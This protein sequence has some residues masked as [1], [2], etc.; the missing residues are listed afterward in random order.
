MCGASGSSSA[1]VRC[2]VVAW[3]A[4]PG[5]NDVGVVVLVYEPTSDFTG[6]LVWELLTLIV[7]VGMGLI[8]AR[9]A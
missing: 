1:Q 7:I 4:V 5:V 9:N 2:A 8:L 3:R 6:P